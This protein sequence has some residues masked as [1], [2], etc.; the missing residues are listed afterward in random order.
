MEI[1]RKEFYLDAICLIRTRF[2]KKISVYDGKKYVLIKSLFKELSFID[3]N[4]FHCVMLESDKK[5]NLNNL[6]D[7]WKEKVD[8]TESRYVSALRIDSV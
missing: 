5:L 7:V 4:K 8:L 3:L 1:V 6:L 2:N